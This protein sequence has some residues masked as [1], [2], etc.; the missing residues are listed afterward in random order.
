MLILDSTV[1]NLFL[2]NIIF[3]SLVR[4]VLLEC[5]ADVNLVTPSYSFF[6]AASSES[7]GAAGRL[8]SV[9]E[10]AN[11]MRRGIELEGAQ[12]NRSVLCNV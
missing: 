10:R 1:V 11:K 12:S 4:I 8:Q 7:L 9:K 2:V 5:I 3:N 6:S